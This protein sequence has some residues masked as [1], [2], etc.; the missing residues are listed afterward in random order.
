MRD[1]RWVVK[2]YHCQFFPANLF[3]DILQY[4]HFTHMQNWLNL[5]WLGKTSDVQTFQP[6]TLS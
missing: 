3:A 2:T 5:D 1:Y 6:K 4:R